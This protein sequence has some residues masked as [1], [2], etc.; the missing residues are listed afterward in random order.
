MSLLLSWK[1]HVMG[2][3]SEQPGSWRV[4]LTLSVPQCTFLGQAFLQ[5]IDT[6][7]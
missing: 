1:T 5:M 6:P 4:D 7:S 2:A 3:V